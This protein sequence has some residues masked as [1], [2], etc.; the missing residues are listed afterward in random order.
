MPTKNSQPASGARDR[1]RR[2]HRAAVAAIAASGNSHCHQ[3]AGSIVPAR[4]DKDQ[5]RWPDELGEIKPD[6]PAG[7]EPALEEAQVECRA[8]GTDQLSLD[9]GGE[10]AGGGAEQEERHE[11][12]DVLSP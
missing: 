9:A 7:D 3:T 4:I 10:A 11:R 1:V 8:F 5:V 6:G 2:D 12:Q